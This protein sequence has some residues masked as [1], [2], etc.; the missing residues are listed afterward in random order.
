MHHGPQRKRIRL[1]AEAYR[2]PASTWLVTISTVERQPAFRNA[3]FA[4]AFLNLA[5]ERCDAA[6]AGLLLVCLM[7]DHVHHILQIGDVG[8]LDIVRDLKS[9]STRLWWQHGGS[10][11]LWQRSFHD[12]GL[13]T[14][15]DVE[16]TVRY[17]LDNPVRAGL[18]EEWEAYP[19]IGGSLVR[20]EENRDGPP[21]PER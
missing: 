16:A 19:Y 7:P 17:V 20:N 1:P 5:Q 4:K 10:G 15:A 8:L 18:V 21:V 2:D 13:R 12:H 9:R 6:G 11:T 14:T 3:G